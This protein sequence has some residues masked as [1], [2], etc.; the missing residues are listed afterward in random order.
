MTKKKKRHADNKIEWLKLMILINNGECK[1][2]ER[3][4]MNHNTH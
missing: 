4:N 1:F 3:K 2:L